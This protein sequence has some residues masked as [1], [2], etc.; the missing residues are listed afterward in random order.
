MTKPRTVP[1]LWENQQRVLDLRNRDDLHCK[2]RGLDDELVPLVVEDSDKRRP[3][4]KKD[5]DVPASE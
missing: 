1:T 4:S 2:E 3:C 5:Q